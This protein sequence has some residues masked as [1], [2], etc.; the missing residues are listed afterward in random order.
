MTNT[1][2]I[3]AAGAMGSD[4]WPRM[5]RAYSPR[6]KDAAK[7]HLIVAIDRTSKFAFVELHEKVTRKTAADFLRHQSRPSPT[8][9]IP[10]SPTTGTHFT[11]PA[12]ETWSP[13]EIKQMI[14]NRQLFRAHAFEYACALNDIDHRL[15]KP[16]HP[17]TNG[18]VERMNRT[19]KDATVKRYFYETH[20]NSAHLAPR[21][22]LV[23]TPVRIRSMSTTASGRFRAAE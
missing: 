1:L 11:D 13:A 7:L 20:D 3:I 9:S 2:H 4:A 8:G 16:K 6:S 12:G 22:S 21:T 23:R 18:Q 19:I 5:A 10:S 14:A 17:W 15:T